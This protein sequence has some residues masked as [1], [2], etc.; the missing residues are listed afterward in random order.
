M[1]LLLD[2][3]TYTVT[4]YAAGGY[5]NGLPNAGA[6]TTLEIRAS[7]QP[8]RG[9][10]LLRAPEG[11]RAAHGIKIYAGRDVVL[12]TVEAVGAQAD[13]ITYDGRVYQIQRVQP[14]GAGAPIPSARY[15]AWASET[16]RPIPP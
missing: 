9:D 2:A 5:T 8:M 13:R 11:L 16:G 15:E 6:T 7:I 4:R 10:E 3:Q 1:I 14:Y 12:R